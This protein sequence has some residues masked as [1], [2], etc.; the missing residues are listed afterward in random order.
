IVVL[1]GSN[2]EG[3][4][5]QGETYHGATLQRSTTRVPLV[6]VAPAFQPGRRVEEPVSL[7]DVLPTL[8]ELLGLP[9]VADV[10]GVS[11]ARPAPADRAIYLETLLPQQ[12][13]GWSP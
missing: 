1:A 6:V 8:V 10:D 4:G 13:F 5:D 12:L 3:L 2:G 7:V 9:P 11:L